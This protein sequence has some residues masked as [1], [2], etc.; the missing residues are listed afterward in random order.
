MWKVQ[1]L[2]VHLLLLGSILSVYFQSTVLSGMEPQVTL[3]ELG[4]RPPAD[5]LVVF[6]TEGLRAESL[7]GDNC[8]GVPVLRDLFME[9]GLVGISISSAP[10]ATR[11]G[12]ISIFAGFNEDP[13]AALTNFGWNPTIFDTVFNRSRTALGW[14]DNNTA[15]IF[16]HL[17][18]GGEP[19]RFETY[20]KPDVSGSL[21]D[22]SVLE[23]VRDFVTKTYNVRPLRNA[24]SV[25]FFVHLADMKFAGETFTPTSSKFKDML[26]STE[27]VVRQIYDL[28]EGAFQDKRTAYLLT[29]D[30]G[31][32]NKGHHGNNSRHEVETPF[33]LWGSGVNRKAPETGQHFIVN[34]EGREL[35][36]YELQQT[37]LAPLMS[38]IIGLP[39]PKNNM[40]LLPLGFVDATVQYELQ[41]M[42]LNTMQLL[43]QASILLT[44]HESGVFSKFMPSYEYL[45]FEGIHQYSL[46]MLGLVNRQR[47]EQALMMSQ[48]MAKQALQCLEYYH[49]YYEQAL[50]MATTAS[51]MLWFLCLL[52][53]LTRESIHPRPARKG[54]VTWTTL[55]MCL[56]GLMIVV[57]MIL[58]NVPCV[59][60]F[61]LLLPYG[62]LI[63]ALG[64][65]P[66][67]G[68]WVMNLIFHL[69]GI[70]MPGFLVILMAFRNNHIGVLYGALA[71][72]NNRKAFLR[73][74][75]KLFS[76]LGLV[77]LL[78]VLL[79]LKQNPSLD[80]I[81][82]S[83]TSYVSDKHVLCFSMVV[84]LV[85][86]LVLQHQH[87]FR[88][89]LVNVASLLVV[90]YGVYQC[91][92]DEPVCTY[93]YLACWAFLAYALLSIP[94]SGIKEPR[95]RLEL[96]IFNM[97][98]AH[99]MLTTSSESLIVQIMVTEFVLGL[100][101]Y[102]ES[103]GP[104]KV[105]DG[106]QNESR[107]QEGEQH[108]GGQ[109]QTEPIDQEPPKGQVPR[110]HL[111]LS[112]RYAFLILLYFYI[113]FF[114]TGHWFFNFTFKNTTSR[115]F[116]SHFCLF[117]AIAFS[118]LKIFI[119]SII[120]IS[121]IYAL[122]TFGRK[123]ARSIF[124]CL[125]LMTEAMSLFF[126]YFVQNRGSWQKVRESLDCLLVTHI[127]SI[128]LLVCAWIAKG[129]L[130]NTTYEKPPSPRPIT[131]IANVTSL[132]EDSQA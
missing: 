43:A 34:D 68:V 56:A 33:I 15:K 102:A 95:R 60:A 3:R 5:R 23:M 80:W 104:K 26:N 47:Y 18:N 59:T 20:S 10:T 39:P 115:L 114:G 69:S 53:K 19:L 94:Y 65:L 98:T 42:H 8:S 108:D 49:T 41:A 44:R 35:P 130:I 103:H 122:V 112:Y 75:V 110:Q 107:D 90:A 96:I 82:N 1:A 24:S 77:I 51:Y 66:T 28:F 89:W 118:L 55:L 97:L 64:E 123:K 40:A 74:S 9:Q 99:I 119:P 30:H 25:V 84:S 45:D 2:L 87:S 31:M 85:R 17:P 63:L 62:I 72:L 76:W 61:Y 116:L 58:Q 14:M 36:L 4:M 120:I 125:F 117:G 67:K 12:H 46:K 48:K 86:P 101:I 106:N 78:S 32:T 27:Q 109:D 81:T 121:S 52:L 79:V 105:K 124:I 73:P 13:S 29:S 21:T 111:R 71:I 113:S 132:S 127:F 22:E 128:L 54:L 70:V 91:D 11:P 93:V 100:D 131:V 38:A 126:C 6:V 57:A 88:V 50:L 7:L 129:F 92:A 16:T 83:I 37:Q